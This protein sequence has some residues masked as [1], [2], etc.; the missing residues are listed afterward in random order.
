L[1]SQ[2][3]ENGGLEGDEKL[4]ER[5]DLIEREEREFWGSER[6]K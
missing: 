6:R 1:R 5:E 4:E 3:E 2:R